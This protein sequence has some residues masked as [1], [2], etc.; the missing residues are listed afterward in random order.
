MSSQGSNVAG[1]LS[2]IS[3]PPLEGDTLEDAIHDAIA[4]ISGLEGTLVRPAWQPEPATIP[5]A[6]TAWAAFRI[7]R[8]EI[9]LFPYV[10][11][12][13]A[14][15]YPPS[16]PPVTPPLQGA[17]QLQQQEQLDVLVSFY[18]LGAAAS[19]GVGGQAD[20]YCALF[21]DGLYIAQNREALMA[22]GI[23]LAY[24]GDAIAV[25]SLLKERWLYRVDLSLTL[26][27]A[28][29]RTYPVYNIESAQ[30]TITKDNPTVTVGFEVND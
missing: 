29:E 18:D 27:R 24:T 8:R 6:A 20:A 21:R 23:V 7:A 28:I 1:Y 5:A 11:H 15:T 19:N 13:G 25:P 4:G 14:Y 26:R 30:G 2:P 17:D 3:T 12:D 16:V 9:S 22:Q 10:G